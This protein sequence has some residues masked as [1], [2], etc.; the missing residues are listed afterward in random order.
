MS[1]QHHRR[2]PG[3]PATLPVTSGPLVRQLFDRAGRLGRTIKDLGGQSGYDAQ[4][5]GGWK[6]QS[7]PKLQS[8]A[9]VGACMDMKL[10]WVI[11]GADDTVH[12]I[13]DSGEAV[14]YRR[15]DE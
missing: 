9:D 3:R 1:K 2:G 14:R 10:R 7:M 4:T 6:K 12:V 8:V 15:I 5:I 13:V 11:E